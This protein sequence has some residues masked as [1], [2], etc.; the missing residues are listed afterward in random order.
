MLVDGLDHVDEGERRDAHAGQRLHLDAGPIRRADA[1]A[2]VDVVVGDVEV[3]LDTVD[4]DGV[5]EVP[6]GRA[7]AEPLP[8]AVLAERKLAGGTQRAVLVGSGGWLLTSVADLSDSLGGGRTALVN[9]GNRELLLSA[10]AWLSGRAD[11]L[12][13]GLSGREVPRIEGLGDG[14]RRAW[15]IALGGSIALG[16]MLVG[17]IVVTRR[18]RR[19]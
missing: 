5:R 10:V 14:V 15:M 16:P 19:G 18:R 6:A 12:D 13:A 2:D 7:I 3:D 9:P 17:G 11:L 4:G 8:V 1:G